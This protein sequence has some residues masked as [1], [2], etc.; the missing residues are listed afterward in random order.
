[1]HVYPRRLA[2]K[3][4]TCF[5]PVECGQVIL[6]T[7]LFFI[8]PELGWTRF[9]N[10][11]TGNGIMYIFKGSEQWSGNCIWRGI[12]EG[13]EEVKGKKCKKGSRRHVSRLS[14]K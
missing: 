9:V 2:L 1:M 3:C 11:G 13:Q 7:S 10:M 8:K 14:Q 4:K 6:L 5:P 12:K